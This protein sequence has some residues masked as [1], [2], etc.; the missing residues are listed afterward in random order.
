MA[1]FTSLTL[2]YCKDTPEAIEKF[3]S[4]PQTLTDFTINTSGNKLVCHISLRD[5]Q[6]WLSIH[7]NT[8]ESIYIDLLGHNQGLYFD[9]S[10]FPNL[11]SLR[12]SR[13]QLNDEDDTWNNDLRWEPSHAN[14]LLS[15]NLTTF[16]MSF[17]ILGCCLINN[18]GA[19][20][21][22]WLRC[23]GQ[24]AKERKSRLKTIEILFNPL[25]AYPHKYGN[26]PEDYGYPWDRISG[27]KKELEKSGIS[28][29]F[30]RPPWTKEEWEGKISRWLAASGVLH[31]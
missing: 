11:S 8:L 20:E 9:A 28:V 25:S 16:G 30:N 3:L 31:T 26:Y 4:W 12:L 19:K 27:L 6:S 23:L 13:T 10:I 29:V 1:S 17:G 7:K 2:K 14:R 24:A 5:A 21:V 18:F 15:P 22:N